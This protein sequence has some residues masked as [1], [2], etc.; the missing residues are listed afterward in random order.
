MRS[1]D[2]MALRRLQERNF[3]EQYSPIKFKIGWQPALQSLP[4][5]SKASIS[6]QARDEQPRRETTQNSI[7]ASRTSGRIWAMAS[8]YAKVSVSLPAPLVERIKKK[9]G[10]RGVSRYVA[11]ALEHEER[12]QA[13]RD[14]LADQDREHGPVPDDVMQEVRR[15][16]LGVD[17]VAS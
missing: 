15:K 16:W 17:S 2:R 14:W 8:D 1:R 12:R 3:E 5:I 13:L 11:E 7:A 10:S 9:V 6:D 4:T